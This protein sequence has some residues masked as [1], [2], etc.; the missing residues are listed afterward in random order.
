[1]KE[2]SIFILESLN[3]TKKELYFDFMDN[4][5]SK[6]C[7]NMAVEFLVNYKRGESPKLKI[8]MVVI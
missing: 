3:T 2:F 4:L 1:M 6:S 8:M 7:D 5:Q